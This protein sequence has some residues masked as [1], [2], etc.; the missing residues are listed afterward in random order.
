MVELS[1]TDTQKEL[2]I[3]DNNKDVEINTF[4]ID[5]NENTPNDIQEAENIDYQTNKNITNSYNKEDYFKVNSV[6]MYVPINFAEE[7][8]QIERQST[9]AI[10]SYSDIKEDDNPVDI[11][12]S[13]E[14]DFMTNMYNIYMLEV[15]ALYKD[16]PNKAFKTGTALGTYIGQITDTGRD[17]LG[18][19]QSDFFSIIGMR[20]DGIS[21]PQKS[22]ESSDLHF[23]GQNIKKITGRVNTPNKVSFTVDLDQSMFILDAFH[24]LNGDWWAK[25]KKAYSVL[26]SGFLTGEMPKENIITGKQFLLNYG[27][28]PYHNKFK[29]KENNKSIIDVI[30]EYDAAYQIMSRYND[31][32]KSNDTGNDIPDLK[33]ERFLLRR[34][35]LQ[36]YILHD[37]RF[38][39][40]SSTISFSNESAEPLKATFPFV[41]RRA[42]KVNDDGYFY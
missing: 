11:L 12:M 34:N 14:P 30:V 38:L 9:K 27:N 36:R 40:R 5:Y 18:T 26:D 29:D 3:Y 8:A 33:D 15:P 19:P 37:C 23:A 42:M 31:I 2:T 6:Q 35:R 25:E 32:S 22:L 21:I 4:S 20:I 39:G 28:L 13:S 41:Y 7:D 1:I 24:R 17:F 16:D 10:K